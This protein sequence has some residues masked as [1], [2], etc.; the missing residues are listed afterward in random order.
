MRPLIPI[1]YIVVLGGAFAALG[2]FLAWKS[3][4]K[5]SVPKRLMISFLRLIGITLLLFAAANPGYEKNVTERSENEIAVLLDKSESMT[6]I[7]VDG[8]ARWSKALSLADE[9]G[10]LKKDQRVSYRVFDGTL[11]SFETGSAKELANVV[12]NGKSTDIS[13]SVR[14]LLSR[15]SSASGVLRKIFILSDGRQTAPE[16]KSDCALL[17]RSKGIPVYTISLG[18]KAPVKDLSLEAA[19]RHFTAFCGQNLNVSLKAENRNLGGVKANVLLYDA[20]GK[21]LQSREISLPDNSMENLSFNIKPEKPGFYEYCAE[22]K[23]PC[24]EINK[25][26]NLFR[27]SVTSI[28]EKIKILFV[29]GVPFWDSKFLAQMLRND[30]NISLTTIYRLSPQRFFSVKTD[31][32]ESSESE[33]PIFPDSFKEISKYNIIIFGKGAEY[34]LNKSRINLLKNFLSESGGAVIFSRAKPYSGSFRELESIE[35]VEWGGALKRNF[36][37]TPTKEAEKTGFLSELLPDQNDSIWS[38]LPVLSKAYRSKRL[39]S[40]TN[41]LIE[42][43]VDSGKG[44]SAAFPVLAFRKYGRGIVMTLNTEG[45]WKWDFFPSSGKVGKFY[46]RFWLQVVHWLIRYSDFLPGYEYSLRLASSRISP[47]EPV[48]VFINARKSQSDKNGALKLKIYNEKN[49]LVKEATP[50]N[51][52]TAGEWSSALSFST[53]GAYKVELEYKKADGKAGK[54]M[55]MIYVKPPLME[56]ENLSSDEGF[57]RELSEKSGGALLNA[58]KF[59]E[60]LRSIKAEK[61]DDN[62]QKVWTP[63]WDK[64]WFL[65]IALGL[66]A[67]EFILRRR[68]G[69]L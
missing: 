52:G 45:M 13:G 65:C 63:L 21:K 1:E 68:N 15:S 59:P 32:S 37:W 69:L 64:W 14:A 43:N 51:S 10:V 16:E 12:P 49:E 46:R 62:I 48:F 55:T 56:M 35:P 18:K 47:G 40:F 67:M 20:S 26:N 38:E 11:Q 44:K 3:T 24:S 33:E 53:P 6:V 4:V 28:K 61:V 34:F 9:F 39:K 19:R 57:L 42:G 25:A 27:F 29:E 17:A 66:F 41:V 36:H 2:A 58:D 54:I 30:P 60:F 22:L 8:A 23:S 5:I 50:V 7:D 31:S